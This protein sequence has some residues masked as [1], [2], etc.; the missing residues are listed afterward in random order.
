MRS[1]PI[2]N[3]KRVL[4]GQTGK[5]LIVV[6]GVMLLFFGVY[7]GVVSPAG[8]FANYYT[9]SRLA[10]ADS[11]RNVKL[12]DQY[13]FQMHLDHYFRG[14]LGSF[15]PFPPSTVLLLIPIAWLGPTAAKIVFVLIN[16]ISL[17]A[18]IRLLHGLTDLPVVT[19][20]G[21]TLLD[22]FSL[23]S[24]VR[25]G[26]MYLLLTLIIVAALFLE[27]RERHFAAG[28][29]LGLAFPIKYFTGVFILYF[30]FEKDLKLFAAASLA[31]AAVLLGGVL[32]TSMKLNLYYFSVVLPMHL[33]GNIQ[34]PFVV[35][36]QSFTSLLNRLLVENDILN[37]DPVFSSPV[38]AMLLKSLISFTFLLL[39]VVAV[40][41]MK[42]LQKRHRVWYSASVI[43]LFGLVTSPVSASYHLVLLI[44]P[45]TLM[46]ATAESQGSETGLH[47]LQH[48]ET[49]YLI[50]YG[51][52]NLVPFQWLCRL[53][54]HSMLQLLAY[55]KLG[56]LTVLY[57]LALS[58]E[59]FRPKQFGFSAACAIVITVIFFF[60]HPVKAVADD[61]AVPAKVDGLIIREM[62]I[63]SGALYYSRESP[64]GFI[65]MRDG[66]RSD[67]VPPE[68]RRT[69]LDGELTAFDSTI[70]YSM[71]VFLRDNRASTATQL[72]YTPGRNSDPAWSDDDRRLYF[73]SDRGRGLDC[74]TVY[75][76]TMKKGNR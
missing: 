53:D 17:I 7:K 76:L 60:I 62:S 35:N 47:F 72:T 41:S 63:N 37:P 30:L 71:E 3:W 69:S 57:L 12:Y 42:Q 26:Q 15:I 20:T 64:T 29:L 44:I 33:S 73:L 67:E 31:A 56:L 74:T 16:M 39:L 21:L 65:R 55:L 36:F 8:D 58:P 46:L 34:N 14:T 11:L 28:I 6:L 43:T 18:V 19:V 2:D 52:I 50:I 38:L 25:E 13:D 1:L 66:I 54:D 4:S 23:W 22:G 61:G 10:L 48:R 40:T 59:V 68:P 49:G 9:S 70:G 5:A 75:F 45:I 27:Q 32:V 24:N 51:A